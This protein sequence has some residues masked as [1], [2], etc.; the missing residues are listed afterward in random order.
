MHYLKQIVVSLFRNCC[1]P[2]P[3]NVYLVSVSGA[4]ATIEH[5]ELVMQRY[6]VKGG[7][8]IL[9]CN[10]SVPLE[11][12]HKVEWRKQD[13]KIFQYVKGRSP[14][15]RFFPTEGFEFSVSTK[16]LFL[17]QAFFFWNNAN[18]CCTVILSEF[19]TEPLI[20]DSRILTWQEKSSVK[21]KGIKFLV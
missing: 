5:L 9:H 10:H 17:L 14:P 15:F 1:S 6:A 21:V 3:L 18:F 7:D 19:I 12:L 4:L 20:D 13:K 8:V 16:L 11:Q 2:I